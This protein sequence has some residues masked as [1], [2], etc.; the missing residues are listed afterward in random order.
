MLKLAL[1]LATLSLGFASVSLYK[2]SSDPYTNPTSQHQTQVEPD[3]FAFGSTIVAAFQVGRFFDGGCSNIGWATSTDGGLTW[4]SG[5]LPSLTVFSTPPGIYDRAS[6]PSVG[7]DAAHRTWM[8]SSLALRRGILGLPAGMGV[9][10]SLSTYG[11]LTWSAPVVTAPPGNLD[12]NWIA[13]DNQYSSPYFGNCYTTWDDVPQFSRLK[14]STSTNGGRNWGPALATANNQTGIGG[15]PVVQPNGT[16]VVPALSANGQ[17]IVSFRSTDGGR[18]WSSSVIVESVISHRTAGGLRMPPLPSAEIDG[19]GTVYVVWPD[20]RFRQDC[21]SNDL[22]MS[23]SVDGVT[24]TPAKRIPIDPTTSGIDHFIP[25]LAVNAATAG[26]NAQLVLTYYYYPRSNCSSADCQLYVGY[27]SSVN[28]GESWNGP[29]Q[30]AGPMMLSWLPSTNQGLMVG[31][32]IS[33]SFSENIAF[34]VFASATEPRGASL[35]Q[36]MVSTAPGVDPIMD[37]A[38]LPARRTKEVPVLSTVS[39]YPAPVQ[40]LTAR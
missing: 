31:D 8:I 12:K 40:P 35:N 22:V 25:G 13:C 4:T 29:T 2:L 10:V 26:K 30:V 37:A 28:G 17:S 9:V 27:I 19:E 20:C 7:Y 11:G 3:T 1:V 39:D 16:V 5:F 23:T 18:S 36:F 24:W 32:Y 21:Q 6:D 38:R 34:P 33:T 15:Q 14:M